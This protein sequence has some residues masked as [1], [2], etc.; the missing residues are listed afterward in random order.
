[1]NLREKLNYDQAKI[2]DAS[3]EISPDKSNDP[4]DYTFLEKGCEQCPVPNCKKDLKRNNVQTHIGRTHL[5][6][7]FGLPHK[8][9]HCSKTFFAKYDRNRHQLNHAK[10]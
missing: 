8:C 2:L 4:H 9:A 7:F 10:G 3:L 1:M 6:Q 5:K